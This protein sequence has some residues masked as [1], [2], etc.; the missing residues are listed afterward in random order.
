MDETKELNE[1]AQLAANFV[2]MTE[3]HVFLTGKAGTGKTTFLRAIVQKTYKNAVVAAPTGIAAINA[4][5][6][7]LH[8]LFQLPFGIFLPENIH[9]DQSNELIHTPASLTSKPRFQ[10]N[11]LKLLRELE[12]LI[13]D[14]VSMLRADTL[15]CIDHTLRFVRRN[16][17]KPFGGVQILFIGDM[18]QLP[19][20]VKDQDWHW[21]KNYYPSQYFF[22]AHALRNS[23][24]VTIELDKIYRQSDQDFIDLLNRMRNAEATLEDIEKL[25]EHYQSDSETYLD[26][27]YIHL[28]THNKQAD[29][30]NARRLEALDGTSYRFSADVENNFPEHLYPISR[31]LELKEGAQVIFIK[32]DPSGQGKYFNGKIGKISKLSHDEICVKPDGQEEIQVGKYTWENAKYSVNK[33]TNEI[34]TQL[35]GTFSQYPLKL[36]WAITVHKSQ[37][38]T[39]EKAVL[40]VS[41]VFAPGQLYVALSR[42]TSLQGLVLSKKLSGKVIS[43][44]QALLD[45]AT[46]QNDIDTLNN[47]LESDK[48]SYLGEFIKQAFDMTALLQKFKA[49]ENSFNKD[50]NRSVR[51]QYAGWTRDLIKKMQ[52]LHDIG[53]RFEQQLTNILTAEPSYQGILLERV[54]KARDYFD[55]ELNKLKKEI[56]E[57]ITKLKDEQH[58]KLYLEELAEL[59]EFY[60]SQQ[61]RMLRAVMLMRHITGK[62]TIS[63]E[64]IQADPLLK[65]RE[66]IEIHGR[67]PRRT[68]AER[69]GKKEKKKPTSEITFELYKQ[70]L[71]IAQIAKERNLVEGTIQSHLCKYIEDGTLSVEEFVTEKKIEKIKAAIQKSESKN[72]GELKT[73]LGDGFSYPEIRMVLAHELF[74]EMNK[75]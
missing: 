58:V 8:S 74:S 14:E 67:R 63:R 49:H 41:G 3:R 51:Q 24:L 11:K 33:N 23:D 2:N 61:K 59:E 18:L 72:A 13:I 17:A 56:K 35:E 7:T 36:A 46:I 29:E 16:R 25:N 62:T 32:N 42:L 40:D 52:E 9:I 39:F 21:L 4:R 54:E 60:F 68:R 66:A 44:D 12:L 71:T 19:P 50:E 47:Q 37:G 31:T 5:G 34:E 15:D 43:F 64:A 57:H 22:D 75:K 1:L 69:T 20:V 30:I 10:G 38:L 6:V 45:F 28:T 70:G 73:E 65:D 27:A 26:K 48:K 55:P 53:K